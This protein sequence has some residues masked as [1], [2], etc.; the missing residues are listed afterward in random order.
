MARFRT[1]VDR[2]VGARDINS[3]VIFVSKKRAQKESKRINFDFRIATDHA[4][5]L[6]LLENSK[7]STRD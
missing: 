5:V 7:P 4:S 6:R 3:R 1:R 2:T